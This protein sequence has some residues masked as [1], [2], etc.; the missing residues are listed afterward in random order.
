MHGKKNIA[1]SNVERDKNV[2]ETCIIFSNNPSIK[3]KHHW[4]AIS[5]LF[6]RVHIDFAGSFM[7]MFLTYNMLVDAYT[8]WKCILLKK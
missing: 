3:I 7:D 4:E 6:Q 5:E 1:H 2:L 8:K